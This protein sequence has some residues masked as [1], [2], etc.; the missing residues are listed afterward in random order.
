MGA[1]ISDLV[2]SSMVSEGRT[3]S[4]FDGAICFVK[5]Y[6]PDYCMTALTGLFLLKA[7]TRLFV[8]ERVTVLIPWITLYS[9]DIDSPCHVSRDTVSRGPRTLSF[10][11]L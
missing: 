11:T 6:Q 4:H 10:S 8:G 7:S 3:A 1:E 5:R 2:A 9:R